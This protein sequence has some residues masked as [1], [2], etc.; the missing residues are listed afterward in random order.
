METIFNEHNAT[1]AY[2][3]DLNAIRVI[4]KTQN[5]SAEYRKTLTAAL[6]GIKKYKAAHYLGDVNKQG[7]VSPNDRK[8]FQDN[9]IPEAVKNGL[10]R[11][12][13]VLPEDIFKKYYL[14]QVKNTTDTLK[15]DMR[16]FP[17]MKQAEDWLEEAIC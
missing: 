12:A 5:T 6:D 11:A 8:W 17:S 16:Y 3:K 1:V 2:E 13:M 7:V 10:K 9:I 15:L 14:N 4:W